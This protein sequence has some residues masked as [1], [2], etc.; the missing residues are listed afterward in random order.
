MDAG[1]DLRS[2]ARATK[3]ELRRAVFVRAAAEVIDRKGVHGITF[4]DVVPTA[5]NYYFRKKEDLAVAC[6][7]HAIAHDDAAGS[8]GAPAHV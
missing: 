6:F 1:T 2:H 4:A 8:I 3:F 5:V 7:L